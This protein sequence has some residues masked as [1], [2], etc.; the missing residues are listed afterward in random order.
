MV[1]T[2][3]QLFLLDIKC[4]WLLAVYLLHVSFSYLELGKTRKLH[5]SHAVLKAEGKSNW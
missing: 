4:W 1:Y 3:K 5:F 2:K